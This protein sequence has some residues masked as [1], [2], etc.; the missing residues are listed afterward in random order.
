MPQEA[1]IDIEIA[2][3]EARGVE[4]WQA[5]KQAADVCGTDAN[6]FLNAVTFYQDAVREI[7]RRGRCLACGY[8]LV[9]ETVCARPTC[10]RDNQ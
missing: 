8:P 1:L 7:E 4:K 10:G 3:A 9:D 2:N 5:A 6:T